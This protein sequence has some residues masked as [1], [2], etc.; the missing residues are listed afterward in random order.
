MQLQG[1]PA[2]SQEA[3]AADIGLGGGGDALTSTSNHNSDDDDDDDVVLE[4]PDQRANELVCLLCDDGGELSDCAYVCL[5][6]CW[7]SP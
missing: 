2:S 1:Q 6:R 3:S 7:I 4:K 5:S